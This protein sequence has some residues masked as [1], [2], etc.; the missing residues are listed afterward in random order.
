MT[1]K[2]ITPSQVRLSLAAFSQQHS[3]SQWVFSLPGGLL[4]SSSHSLQCEKGEQGQSH[5]K[6]K[7][8]TPCWDVNLRKLL[9]A[10]LILEEA[11]NR[12]E[13]KD[14]IISLSLKVVRCKKKTKHKYVWSVQLVLLLLLQP[15]YAWIWAHTNIQWLWFSSC[16]HQVP[17]LFVLLWI[18]HDGSPVAHHQDEE[19]RKQMQ[20]SRIEACPDGTVLTQSTS[21]ITKHEFEASVYSTPVVCVLASTN[22]LTVPAGL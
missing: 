8:Q 5:S 3:V 9:T 18:S 10:L 11:T 7:K 4:I 19:N 15:S 21:E 20:C 6:N 13:I 1:I 2:G 16:T 12:T 17:E 14:N 22:V